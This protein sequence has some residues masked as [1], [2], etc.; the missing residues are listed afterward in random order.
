M[1]LS[2][3]IHNKDSKIMLMSKKSRKEIFKFLFREGVCCA[4][5]NFNLPEH[6]RIPVPNLHVIKS[7]QS[8]KSRGFVTELFAWRHFYWF[9]TS[10]GVSYLRDYLALP[11]EILPATYENQ[12][13]HMKRTS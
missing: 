9:L 3:P 13:R 1:G 11:A 4:E 7:M 10:D 12:N 2:Q 6:P 8:L 5:K